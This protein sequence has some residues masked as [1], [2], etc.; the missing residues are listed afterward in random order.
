MPPLEKPITVL[1]T[2]A[3][4]G[5][6]FEFARQYL[7]RGAC[8]I[9]TCRNPNDA[10]GLNT[11][12][13]DDRLLILPMDVGH[14]GSIGALANTLNARGIAIDILINNAGIF[15]TKSN[16]EGLGS[17]DFETALR[18]FRTN[19]I[20]SLMVTQALHPLLSPNA[21]IATIASDFASIGQNT[22]GFPYYYAGSKAA[23]N[24]MMRSLAAD[25]RHEKICVI[26]LDPGWVRTD[27]GGESAPLSP[28]QSIAGMIQVIDKV[29]LNDS[30]EFLTWQGRKQIW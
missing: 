23:Q 8:V 25:L 29:S 9:A 15:P 4:R 21:K 1:I 5:L 27:M 3:N 2:G 28:E 30:G 18:V 17:F 16:E 14:E 12:Q 7:Q 6:G 20:A 19:A 13:T 24:M 11:L 10:S 26:C 22:S